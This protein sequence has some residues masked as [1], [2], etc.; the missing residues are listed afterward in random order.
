MTRN[1]RQREVISNILQE[2]DGPLSV[3]VIHE[4]ATAA[5]PSL[6]L[7]TVYRTLKLLQAQGQIHSLALDGETVYE[8]SGQGHHHHFS[9]ERCKQVFTLHSCPLTLPAGGALAG[10]WVV[11]SHEITLYGVCPQCQEGT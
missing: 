11:K 8:R 10:G 4:R 5:L 7:A 6:G 9:C 3:P 2:A 1:T